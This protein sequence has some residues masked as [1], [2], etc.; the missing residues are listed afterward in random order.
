MYCFTSEKSDPISFNHF[1]SR[2][3]L[4]AD[5]K[6]GRT[7]LET[8]KQKQINF[9]LDLKKIATGNRKHKSKEQ[10]EALDNIKM[11][12]NARAEKLLNY[13]IIIL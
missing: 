12:Y 7:E 13:M 8:A 10:T 3:V 11:L 9:K 5:M 6:D 4:T 1:R 2:L